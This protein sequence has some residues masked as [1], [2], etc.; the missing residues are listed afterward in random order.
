MED[1][2]VNGS[3]RECRIERGPERR[4]GC[5]SM[6]GP[7]RR[8]CANDREVAEGVG[9]VVGACLRYRCV[10]CESGREERVVPRQGGVGQLSL[11]ILFPSLSLRPFRRSVSNLQPY[12]TH[13]TLTHTWR[14]IL[15]T[16]VRTRIS[17]IA[18]DGASV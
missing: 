1:G 7:S 6:E 2:I 5:Q 17:F 18:R 16:R 8:H 9:L 3:V 14:W 15:C 4:E 10:C 11:S 13:R 12:T